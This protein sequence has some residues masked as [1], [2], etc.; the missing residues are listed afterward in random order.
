MTHVPKISNITVL[1]V[2]DSLLILSDSF[3]GVFSVW[4]ILT[5]LLEQKKLLAVSLLVCR[6]YFIQAP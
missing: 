5:P 1:H 3:W 6:P 2:S 4:Q